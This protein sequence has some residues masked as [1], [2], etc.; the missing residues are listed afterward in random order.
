MA[1][2]DL[3][4]LLRKGPDL[5]KYIEGK[6]KKYTTYGLGASL[7]RVD[8]AQATGILSAILHQASDGEYYLQPA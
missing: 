3:K 7:Y 6:K 1:Q 8:E 5:D 4:R 2:K